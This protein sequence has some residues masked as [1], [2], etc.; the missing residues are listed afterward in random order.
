MSAPKGK[1]K[2]TPARKSPPPKKPE[3]AIVQPVQKIPFKSSPPKKK[4]KVPRW[5]RKALVIATLAFGIDQLWLA[6][7]PWHDDLPM[8][9]YAYEQKQLQER[10]VA[11]GEKPGVI[12]FDVTNVFPSSETEFSDTGSVENVDRDV[13]LSQVGLSRLLAS[14]SAWH[15]R[16]IVVDWNLAPRDPE[17][18]TPSRQRTELYSTIQRLNDA[19]TPV[20]FVD[21]YSQTL[22]DVARRFPATSLRSRA[23]TMAVP[24][25]LIGP[26]HSGGQAEPYRELPPLAVALVQFLN[27]DSQPEA[28]WKS[29]GWGLSTEIE[30][31]KSYWINFEA[32]PVILVE[33]LELSRLQ[34]ETPYFEP[35]GTAGPEFS[36]QMRAG[37]MLSGKVVLIGDLVRPT[38]S[39]RAIIPVASNL[40]PGA[41]LA[42]ADWNE[43]A[44]AGVLHHACAIHTLLGHRLRSFS[45]WIPELSF[46]L[47]W[48]LM[49]A[50]ICRLAAFCMR[51]GK[52]DAETE[53]QRLTLELTVVTLFGSLALLAL[54]GRADLHGILIPVVPALVIANIVEAVINAFASVREVAEHRRYHNSLS[55][56]PPGAKPLKPA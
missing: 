19:G 51:L 39:D 7:Q 14:M 28:I 13:K 25:P 21:N 3:A 22:A 30:D 43:A 15:P 12:V 6:K 40:A 24:S 29:A 1:K 44:H 35:P 38:A 23:V 45:G 16:A 53:L 26:Y 55:D 2:R 46:V 50:A 4:E 49:W 11:S 56:D 36:D 48:S 31:E 54:A 33:S 5:L 47:I 32:L 42:T 18:N 9:G 34:G 27:R 10:Y 20:F 52:E 41:G 37:K 8:S 17:I